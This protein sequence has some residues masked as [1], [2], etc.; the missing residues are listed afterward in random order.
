MRCFALD[1]DFLT[2]DADLA[3]ERRLSGGNGAGLATYRELIRNLASKASPDGGALPVVLSRH[4]AR[5]CADLAAREIFP[6]DVRFETELKKEIY[7]TLS[8][9]EGGGG[10]FDLSS[11][12]GLMDMLGGF[13]FLRMASMVG[14]MGVTFTKEELLDINAKLNK[15]KNKGE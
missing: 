3:P 7:A 10:G 8:A 14:T 1:R 2:A 13:T 15:I 6:E 11:I 4:Y 12:G 5:L 9:L